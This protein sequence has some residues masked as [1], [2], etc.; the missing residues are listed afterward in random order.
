MKCKIEYISTFR[1]D[2]MSIVESL[3]E[4]PHKASRIFSQLDKSVANLSEMP[5]MHFI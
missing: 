5:E 2:V 3:E 1:S 4:Y